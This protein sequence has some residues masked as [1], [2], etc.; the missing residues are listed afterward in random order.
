MAGKKSSEFGILEVISG[1]II[2]DKENVD[3]M[4]KCWI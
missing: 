1:I 3:S 2:Y 4:G